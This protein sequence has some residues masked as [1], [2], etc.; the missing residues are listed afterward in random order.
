MAGANALARQCVLWEIIQVEGDD[1]IGSALD[2]GS[3]NMTVIRV[4]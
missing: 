2:G 3:Q 4:W 1:Q